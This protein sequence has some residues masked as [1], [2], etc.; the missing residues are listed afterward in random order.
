MLYFFGTSLI[1]RH[2]TAVRQ[3]EELEERASVV[4][5]VEKFYKSFGVL[6][7]GFMQNIFENINN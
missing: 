6:S 5:H 1:L 7:F 3:S 2:L 4:F